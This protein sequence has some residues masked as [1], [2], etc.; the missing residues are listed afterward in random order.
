VDV[1]PGRRRRGGRRHGPGPGAVGGVAREATAPAWLCAGF[2]RTPRT[3][4][5]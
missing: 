3:R 2:A 4:C 5:G 1:E